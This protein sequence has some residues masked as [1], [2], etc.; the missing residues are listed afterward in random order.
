M[1]D[2]FM[3]CIKFL[4]IM[5]VTIDIKRLVMIDIEYVLR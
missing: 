5:D 4:L 1:N 2:N 3:L